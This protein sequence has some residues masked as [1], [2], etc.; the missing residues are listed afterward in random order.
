MVTPEKHFERA[1]R[2]NELLR[3]AISVLKGTSGVVCTN[4]GKLELVLVLKKDLARMD[5]WWQVLRLE[6]QIHEWQ[7]RIRQ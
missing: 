7:R 6:N 5:A 3:Y 1:E 4:K 2:A